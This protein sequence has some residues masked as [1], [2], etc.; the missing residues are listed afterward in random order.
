MK[1]DFGSGRV[2]RLR[3]AV[4]PDRTV[5]G[6][7]VLEREHYHR[8][9]RVGTLG[10][11]G[12]V[13]VDRGL[14]SPHGHECFAQF[15]Q[16]IADNLSSRGSYVDKS[17]RNLPGIVDMNRAFAYRIP[18]AHTYRGANDVDGTAD[19]Q[20]RQLFDRLPDLPEDRRYGNPG[21]YGLPS[22]DGDYDT[23][24]VA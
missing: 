15:E 12:T 8:G 21:R 7:P 5:H 19:D 9:R 20:M 18:V 10:R 2:P 11:A 16:Q 23:V 14:A 1:P 13:S 17:A 6:N 24:E 4:Q 22:P 3:S